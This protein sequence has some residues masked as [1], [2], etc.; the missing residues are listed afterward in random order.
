[1]ARRDRPDYPLGRYNCS[2]NYPDS[3]DS[4]RTA[5]YRPYSPTDA[6]LI[7]L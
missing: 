7:D 3:R 1:M 4:Y 2:D 6:E 5:P